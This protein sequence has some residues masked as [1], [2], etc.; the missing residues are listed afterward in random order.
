MTRPSQVRRRST[1]PLLREFDLDVDGTRIR[2]WEAGHGIPLILLHGSGAGVSMMSNYKQFVPYATQTFR[3]VGTDLIGFGHSA[4]KSA[5]P[6]FDLELWVRQ[7]QSLIDWCAEDSVVV[8]G[9]SLSGALALRVAARDSRVSGVVTTGTMGAPARPGGRRPRWRFPETR[10]E[11]RTQ[12]ERT[13]ARP[14]LVDEAELDAREAII[15]TP[16]YR[17][18]FQRMF[19]DDADFHIDAAALSENE[20]KSISCPAL[21]MHGMDD[22]SFAPEESSLAL[23]RRIPNAD[24]HVLSNC[25]HSV[26]LEQ[27]RKLYEAVMTLVAD[28]PHRVQ[29]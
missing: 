3:V 1:V 27:P 8:L 28:L 25:A 26:A 21:L 18:Y 7:A 4:R 11:L 6:Y 17:E 23:A 24:V 20:L 16:G 22:R 10:E 14:E 13:V 29:V 2:C 5:L 12:V 15:R 9:H 19:S